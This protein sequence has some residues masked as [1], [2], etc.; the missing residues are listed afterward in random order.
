MSADE[1]AGSIVRPRVQRQ[2]ARAQEQTDSRGTPLA[3]EQSPSRSTEGAEAADPTRAAAA[4]PPAAEI[5]P[6]DQSQY[7]RQ[8]SL[9]DDATLGH[10]AFFLPERLKK[11]GW[12]YEWKV[13]EVVGQPARASDR[14]L[15]HN[16]GWRPAPAA[17]WREILPPD[18][19]R[20]NVEIDGQML[21]MRPMRLSREAAEELNAKAMRQKEDK[22][23]SAL[24]GDP[25]GVANHDG[26]MPRLRPN[27]TLEGEVGTHRTRAA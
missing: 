5:D 22:L 2:S 18:Y 8:S 4:V 20:R 16:Q 19:E 15:E 23:K 12:D 6:Y 26:R 21:M 9:I 24:T 1:Q 10:G 7:S 3:V 14:A 27:I 25:G 11:P 17:D 13:T